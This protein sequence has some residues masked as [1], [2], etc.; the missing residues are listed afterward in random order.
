MSLWD[1]QKRE[2]DS[3]NLFNSGIKRRHDTSGF[4]DHGFKLVGNFLKVPD[5]RN[6][7]VVDPDFTLYDGEVVL[8]VEIK[9]GQNI[10]DRHIEQMNDYNKLGREAVEEFLKDTEITDLDLQ[11]REFSTFDHCIVYYEN[12]IQKCRDE[13]EGCREKLEELQEVAPVVT[14]KRG[15]RLK[16]DCGSF[17]SSSLESLLRE[18]IELPK[19]TDKVIYL[20]EN[21]EHECLS[22]SICHDIVLNNLKDDFYEISPSDVRNFYGRNIPLGKINR[23]FEFLE[24]IGVCTS[25]SS[26]GFRFSDGNIR[27]I[28]NIESKLRE[29]SVEDHLDDVDD[30]QSGLDEFF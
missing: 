28:F 18:D 10:N 22:Y 21:V 20:T 6:E 19:A 11:P 24:H 12:F 3:Y 15:S 25:I 5:H 4:Q 29:K 1:R 26:G 16:H 2:I 27:S 8:F 14:Q 30:E 9:S 23:C 13:W 7:V 17:N